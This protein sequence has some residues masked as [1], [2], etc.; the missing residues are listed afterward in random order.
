MRRLTAPDVAIPIEAEQSRPQSG[1]SGG[2]NAGASHVSAH[3]GLRKHDIEYAEGNGPAVAP[4]STTSAVTVKSV[5][6]RV[7]LGTESR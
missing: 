1:E 6:R 7:R 4:D 3:T 2:G 5:P